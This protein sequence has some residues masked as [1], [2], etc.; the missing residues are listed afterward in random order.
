MAANNSLAVEPHEGLVRDIEK[1]F[2][3]DVVSFKT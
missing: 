3:R 1:I 2:G